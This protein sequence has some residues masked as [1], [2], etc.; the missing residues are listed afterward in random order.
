M[1]FI[2]S[3]NISYEKLPLVDRASPKVLSRRNRAENQTSPDSIAQDAKDAE[4]LIKLAGVDVNRSLKD[5]ANADE[6][7]MIE[8]QPGNADIHSRQ[9][10]DDSKRQKGIRR[11]HYTRLFV[12]DNT[13]VF[14]AACCLPLKII[15]AGLDGNP[16]C[17]RILYN[18]Y[19]AEDGGKLV[20]EFQGRGAEIIIDL[21]RGLK[22][23]VT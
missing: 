1:I 18:S 8:T 6:K 14:Q 15:A 10:S 21:M 19:S 4:T 7:Y 17:G 12:F 20:Y 23:K 3:V 16:V 9:T 22:H 13:L 2:S 5:I 11:P